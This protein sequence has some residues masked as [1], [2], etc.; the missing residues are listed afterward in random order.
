MT[1]PTPTTARKAP[2]LPPRW[3]GSGLGGHPPE[4]A[5]LPALEHS[6]G[7]S[8]TRHDRALME[9][10]FAADVHEFGRSRPPLHTR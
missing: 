7:R 1:H 10:T 6:L 3:E 8:E 4:P 2:P 5:D 9:A